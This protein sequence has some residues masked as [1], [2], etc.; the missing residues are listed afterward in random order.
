MIE[1]PRE[2]LDAWL[3]GLA[4][5]L[6]L[7]TLL[8]LAGSIVGVW[9]R[10]TYNLTRADRAGGKV[11]RPDFLDVDA[12]KREAAIAR[13][14]AYD[15]TLADRE[16][17]AAPASAVASITLWSR[18]AALSAAVLTLIATIVGTVTRVQALEA[19]VQQVGTWDQFVQTIADHKVG[20]ALAVAVIGAQVVVFV[21]SSKKQFQAR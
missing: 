6:G 19:S 21:Q 9:H 12:R 14:R 10:R 18:L 20:A 8:W 2:T 4:W 3:N 11:V 17:A 16:T 13:G 5:T 15:K 1:I 7:C